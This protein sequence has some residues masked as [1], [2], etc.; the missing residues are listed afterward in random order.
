MPHWVQLSAG[1]CR[2]METLLKHRP[3]YPNVYTANAV[4]ALTHET[5]HSIGI[6]NEA[7][8]E[9]F[10]MQLSFALADNL[11]VPD[12]YSLRLARLNLQNY[13]D[14]PPSYIN[15]SRCREDGQWDLFPNRDSPPWHSLA[16]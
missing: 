15:A 14:R 5:M 9:C 3:L 13:A 2:A 11:G 16:Q 4:E 8:A 10:G 12:A 7:Q 1:V 6:D